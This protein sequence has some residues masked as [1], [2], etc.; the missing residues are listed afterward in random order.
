[1]TYLIKEILE[2][3]IP[4]G[5]MQLL[6]NMADLCI[7]VQVELRQHFLTPIAVDN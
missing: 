4:R 1:M 7:S 2:H 3:V 6:V 5:H